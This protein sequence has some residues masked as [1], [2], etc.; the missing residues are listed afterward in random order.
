MAKTVGAKE[1]LTEDKLTLLEGWARNGL[2][3]VQI[4][5]NMGI[6]E[7]T[8]KEWRKKEP[9]I[10]DAM[11]KGREVV[12]FEVENALYKNAINGNV[13]AQIFWLKNRRPKE[14]R[15]KI[16]ISDNTQINKLDALLQEIKKDANN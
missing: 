8:L 7:T 1:W 2:T 4:A 6:G 3:Y 16:E 15:E 10:N 9:A 12:D 11:K 14:W 13:T 5:K